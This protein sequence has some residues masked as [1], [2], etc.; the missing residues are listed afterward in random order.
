M[1][2]SASARAVLVILLSIPVAACSG[3]DGDG[4][5]QPCPDGSVER[6]ATNVVAD[7]ALDSRDDAI[8]AG[9]DALGV[10]ASKEAIADAIVSAVAVP[11]SH[12][13][14]LTIAVAGGTDVLLTLTP[15]DPGWAVERAEW[16]ATA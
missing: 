8:Q 16:C 7:P 5:A 1:S 13:E 15:L 9:L 3:S 2:P 4:S 12:D 11:D 6:T 10:E 14:Q